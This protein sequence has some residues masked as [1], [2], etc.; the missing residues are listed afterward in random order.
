M[1]SA[2]CMFKYQKNFYDLKNSERSLQS[3]MFC[4]SP[5]I[6]QHRTEESQFYPRAKF[7]SFFFVRLILDDEEAEKKQLRKLFKKN[8]PLG[9]RWKIAQKAQVA[10]YRQMNYACN[11]NSEFFKIF[12]S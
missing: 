9:L 8:E 5:N 6:G 11:R 2:V 4:P 1:D 10:E 3:L 7:Q 12:L